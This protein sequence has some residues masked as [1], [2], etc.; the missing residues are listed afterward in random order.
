MVDERKGLVNK[1]KRKI[2][3][4]FSFYSFSDRLSWVATLNK[5]KISVTDTNK[6][7]VNEYKN[8]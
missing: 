8:Q 4:I 6:E 2:D 3:T 7:I 1:I 5:N